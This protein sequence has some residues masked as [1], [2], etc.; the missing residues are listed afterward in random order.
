MDTKLVNASIKI[1]SSHRIIR[2]RDQA[3]LQIA[4]NQA[5]P[6]K[7][8]VDSGSSNHI[9]TNKNS[10]SKFSSNTPQ[11]SQLPTMK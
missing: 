5:I 3:S 6:E 9:T 4:K 11:I 8:Y 1:L 2:K 7:W 10:M